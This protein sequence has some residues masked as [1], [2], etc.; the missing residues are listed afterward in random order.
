MGGVLV[1]MMIFVTMGINKVFAIT[2]VN[3]YLGAIA[4][5]LF[6]LILLV[7]TLLKTKGEKLFNRLSS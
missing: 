6:L 1:T 3:L 5:L 2:N 7:Y 4:L